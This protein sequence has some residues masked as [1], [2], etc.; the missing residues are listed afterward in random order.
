MRIPAGVQVRHG[1]YWYSSAGR[2]SDEKFASLTHQFDNASE[3]DMDWA[4]FGPPCSLS[5]IGIFFWGR[6]QRGQ[7]S[8]VRGQREWIGR[9]WWMLTCS[10]FASCYMLCVHLR[11]EFFIA[12]DPF[13]PFEKPR[14]NM[15]AKNAM[16]ITIVT[17]FPSGK[18]RQSLINYHLKTVAG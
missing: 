10:L 14:K 1:W 2:R 16:P 5:L 12:R 13:E 7:R 18:L 4:L 3:A 15:N 11:A 6:G 8:E 17:G 9:T